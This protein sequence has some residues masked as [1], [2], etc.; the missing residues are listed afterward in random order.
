[1]LIHRQQIQALTIRRIK[2]AWYDEDYKIRNV[3]RDMTRPVG[4]R[5]DYEP[6]LDGFLRRD[7]SR[8]VGQERGLQPP[9]AEGVAVG[10]EQA[11]LEQFE[12]ATANLP[13][14]PTQA[15]NLGGSTPTSNT[16]TPSM[17]IPMEWTM[18]FDEAIAGLTTPS[19]ELTTIRNQ[20]QGYGLP[21]GKAGRQGQILASRALAEIEMN[22]KTSLTHLANTMATMMM[23]PA[24]FQKD[25]WGKQ[26]EYGLG[27]R[28]LGIMERGQAVEE[29]LLPEKMAAIRE[30]APDTVTG[31]GPGGEK[32]LYG[33]DPEKRSWKEMT[34]GALPVEVGPG[35]SVVDPS[36]GKA[37]YEGKGSKVSDTMTTQSYKV[38]SDRLKAIENKYGLSAMGVSREKKSEMDEARASEERQ[39]FREFQT[40]LRRFGHGEFAQSN[41]PSLD[42]LKAAAKAQGSRMSDDELGEYYNERYGAVR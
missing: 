14:A 2:M 10:G 5:T 22:R 18:R 12:N 28:K 13:Q 35:H 37:L 7:L 9:R 11:R 20:A 40:N 4:M 26:L 19:P 41:R 1:M 23:K 30:K 3:V 42:Q 24:E 34:K 8:T 16:G 6:G 36:T 32:I 33:W 39:A 17:D 25:I 27:Q 29:A 15:I 31:L 38:Y 21:M